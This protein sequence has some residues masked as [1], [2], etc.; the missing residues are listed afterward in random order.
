MGRL[1]VPDQPHPA[2]RASPHAAG[3]LL[4]AGLRRLQHIVLRGN[5]TVHADL[6]RWLSASA[7]L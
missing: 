7:E 2:P 6:L 5:Y 1:R 3:A 4:G